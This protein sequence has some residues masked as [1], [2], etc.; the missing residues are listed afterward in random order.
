[1][2][3]SLFKGKSGALENTVFAIL[4]PGGE[5]ALTRASRSPMRQFKT[6]EAFAKHLES[7]Y[8]DFARKAK[9]IE[10]LPLH[11]EFALAVNVA[12]CDQLPLVILHAKDAKALRK[13]EQSVAE[14]AWSTEHQGL[15]HYCSLQQ[16]PA[17][18]AAADAGR[19]VK[20][21][22]AV[23]PEFILRE[24]V[25]VLAP[26]PFGTTATVLGFSGLDA[27]VDALSAMLR[28][29]R[30]D[31]DPEAKDRRVHIGNARK[32]GISWESE[33]PVTDPK[34]RRRGR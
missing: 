3:L 7:T 2:L 11:N 29:A 15:Q 26:G 16:D 22:E 27:D 1:M 4:D 25:T 12:A 17:P 28:D 24:G 5:K 9:P 14:L 18:V 21:G 8:S 20:N 30:A 6:P 10:Q 23:L 19:A 31:H 33:L 34:S 13:L 32:Q